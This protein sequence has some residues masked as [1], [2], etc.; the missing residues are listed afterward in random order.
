MGCQNQGKMVKD[1]LQA[2]GP[3]GN[4][5]WERGW[6]RSGCR[7]GL[8]REE[9]KEKKGVGERAQREGVAAQG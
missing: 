6:G 3:T 5:R 1:E 2:W 4:C 9:E 8:E 7:E